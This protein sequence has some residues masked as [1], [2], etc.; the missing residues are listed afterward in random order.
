MSNEKKDPN[1]IE[2]PTTWEEMGDDRKFQITLLGL[3]SITFVM[4]DVMRELLDNDE[5]M[6]VLMADR[7][8]SALHSSY[9]LLDQFSDYLKPALLRVMGDEEIADAFMRI[10]K[11]RLKQV[12]APVVFGEV[13]KADQVVKKAREMEER[14]YREEANRILGDMKERLNAMQ[15]KAA[16]KD[17]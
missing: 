13:R 2:N 7:H 6:D 14:E 12:V 4:T 3:A 17:E 8:Y 10:Y 1:G 5:A 11:D 15:A 16:G 9:T